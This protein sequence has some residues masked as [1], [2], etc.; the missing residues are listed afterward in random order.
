[1]IIETGLTVTSRIVEFPANAWNMGLDYKA[2]PLRQVWLYVI[3]LWR[4]CCRIKE[5]SGGW[6]TYSN[7]VSVATSQH[8]ASW[9]AVIGH[10]APELGDTK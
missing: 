7:P 2:F 10:S 9:Q 5:L 6:S 1:V 3:L 8:P 4:S